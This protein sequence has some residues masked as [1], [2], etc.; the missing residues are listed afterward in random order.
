M[1]VYF[2]LS[3]DLVKWYKE[4]LNKKTALNRAIRAGI[5]VIDGKEDAMM[6]ELREIKQMISDARLAP[7]SATPPPQDDFSLI[8]LE[9][10]AVIDD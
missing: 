2:D 3:E 10:M 9:T 8:G 4:Q 7:A 6:Q 1:R 5:A